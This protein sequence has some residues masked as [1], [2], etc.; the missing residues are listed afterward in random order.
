MLSAE[1]ILDISA[2]SKFFNE[3]CW[4]SLYRH[5]FLYLCLVTLR[6]Y[7]FLAAQVARSI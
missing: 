1:K 3:I 4:L 2:S 6:L 7:L 5:Y